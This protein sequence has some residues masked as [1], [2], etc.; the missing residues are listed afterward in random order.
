M[1]LFSL[2]M[3]IQL[4]LYKSIL[5][6]SI[7]IVTLHSH[8]RIIHIH[9]MDL[10]YCPNSVNWDTGKKNI[11]CLFFSLWAQP[12]GTI[13]T[14]A[15]GSREE[16]QPHAKEKRWKHHDSLQEEGSG[17]NGYVILYSLY[18][19]FSFF[20]LQHVEKLS[21]SYYLVFKMFCPNNISI[22]FSVIMTELHNNQP[23][24]NAVAY[25]GHCTFM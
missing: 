19:E 24:Y 1:V 16:E 21:A 7:W 12:E 11:C 5:F 6:D 17:A 20:L 15:E 14:E 25:Y 4:R 22:Y 10:F 18:V 2:I 23:C 8:D 9:V 3:F 13:Q